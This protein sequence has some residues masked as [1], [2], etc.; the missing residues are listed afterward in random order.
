MSW[1]L[2]MLF[3]D[4]LRGDLHHEGRGGVHV[5]PVFAVLKAAGTDYYQLLLM[6]LERFD[7]K[8]FPCHF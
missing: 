4:A 1:C 8:L 2:K 6:L 5:G 3:S 7:F